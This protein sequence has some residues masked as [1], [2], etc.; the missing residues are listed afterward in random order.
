[1][2]WP[3]GIDWASFINGLTND[4]DDTTERLW[5]NWD[6]DW[7]PNISADLASNQTFCAVH[8]N[9]T[10]CVLSFKYNIQVMTSD[11]LCLLLTAVQRLGIA[12]PLS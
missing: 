8:C 3:L 11:N 1:M 9:S 5:S 10:A 2:Y 4:I 12:H 6:A 7:W